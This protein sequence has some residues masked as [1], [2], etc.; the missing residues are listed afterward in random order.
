MAMT[1]RS[2]LTCARTDATLR[3]AAEQQLTQAAENNFVSSRAHSTTNTRFLVSLTAILAHS[4][5]TSRLWYKN[6]PT[7]MQMVL[8]EPPPVL[9]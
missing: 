4:P 3:Q 9:P 8:S 7:K 5:F 1:T 6:S 2:Q